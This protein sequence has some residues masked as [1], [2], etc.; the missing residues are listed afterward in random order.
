MAKS[1]R[2]A[3]RRRRFN[4]QNPGDVNKIFT[5]FETV[6]SDRIEMPTMPPQVGK[7]A[8]HRLQSERFRL[9]SPGDRA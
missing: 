9:G 6:V 5:R 7:R 3:L 8:E 4:G 2:L 1:I